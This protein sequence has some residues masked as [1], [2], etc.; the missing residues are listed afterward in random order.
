[1]QGELKKALVV[2]T[3]NGS[4]YCYLYD[5]SK[6]VKSCLTLKLDELCEL[7]NM[8][9]S[10]EYWSIRICFTCVLFQIILTGIWFLK[11]KLRPI[12]SKI[13]CI[14]FTYKV[15]LTCCSYP[16]PWEWSLGGW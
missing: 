7:A 5:N 11:I 14:F 6:P 4:V 16:I 1:M 3:H 12:L 8:K 2:S 15:W 9:V 13:I 10:V